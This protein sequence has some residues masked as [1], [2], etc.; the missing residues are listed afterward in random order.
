MKKERLLYS[1]IATF[2][3]M[4]ISISMYAQQTI[5]GTLR[6]PSG[7]VL[8]GAT[9]T[10][11]GTNRSVITDANGQFAI[12]APVGS[13]LV[14]SSVGFQGREIAVTGSEINETLQ[15]GDATLNEVVVIG[16]QTV[17]RRDLTGAVGI[18]HHR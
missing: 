12:D 10:V 6:A 9:V 5:R 7:E 4:L 3:A 8:A 11:K 1:A 18:I 15:P 17:R 2:V 16:Y 13:T 14:V